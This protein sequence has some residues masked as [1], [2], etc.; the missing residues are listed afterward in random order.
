MTFCASKASLCFLILNELW[1]CLATIN[2]KSNRLTANK[3]TPSE[4][5]FT[6]A[7]QITSEQRNCRNKVLI[8][9]HLL[10]PTCKL[11]TLLDSRTINFFAFFTPIYTFLK[12]IFQSHDTFPTLSKAEP[13]HAWFIHHW[14]WG[15]P[16]SLGKTYEAE[17]CAYEIFWILLKPLKPCLLSA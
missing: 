7:L 12:E 9:A 17:L 13:I 10:D 3:Q 16:L 15:C 1:N 4:S 11:T 5:L 14:F 6:S 2:T 8:V